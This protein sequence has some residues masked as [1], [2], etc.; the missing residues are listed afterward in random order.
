MI[1]S[2]SSPASCNSVR[3]SFT[4]VGLSKK[5][6]DPRWSG[7]VFFSTT[8]R[9][10]T[11]MRKANHRPSGSAVTSR[12]SLESDWVISAVKCSHDINWV[13]ALMMFTSPKV[14]M[15]ERF[16]GESMD[17]EWSNQTSTAVPFSKSVKSR[18]RI[19]FVWSWFLLVGPGVKPNDA[20]LH[21]HLAIH[22]IQ[23]KTWETNGIQKRFKTLICLFPKNKAKE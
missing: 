6:H 11:P 16:Y 22:Q 13:M 5:S 17:F 9:L 14:V 10:S 7:I 23:K 20:K 19:T 8:S 18:L 21:C 2:D 1:S 15:L 12:A 3:M 4:V